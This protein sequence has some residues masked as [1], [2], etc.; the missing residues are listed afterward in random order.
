M[1]SIDQHPIV[2][3]T[4]L[5]ITAIGVLTASAGT[6]WYFHEQGLR[7]ELWF[8]E[9]VDWNAEQTIKHEEI[10]RKQFEM[11]DNLNSK[12]I[13]LEG[14]DD[15]IKQLERGQFSILESLA[16]TREAIARHQG[17]HDV[18]VILEGK[19]HSDRL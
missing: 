8:R 2:K 15:R 12:D 10:I 16:K 17:H 7:D 14:I 13:R 5:I 18:S 4:L 19:C 3:W 6:W 9:D 1:A 11:L